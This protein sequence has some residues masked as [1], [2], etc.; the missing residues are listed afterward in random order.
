M[1]IMLVAFWN[2]DVSNGDVVINVVMRRYY[3]NEGN[4]D[5]EIIMVMWG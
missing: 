2:S 5:V 1:M 4:G 3:G